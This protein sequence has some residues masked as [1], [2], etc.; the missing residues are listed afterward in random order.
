MNIRKVH[1]KSDLKTFID[2]PHKLYK[3]D[4]NYVPQLFVAMKELM[5]PD[6]NPWF[7]HSK[8]DLFL[9]EKQ[10]EIVGRIAAIRNNQYID[11]SG[12]PKGFFGFF[13][14]I[15]DY[16]VARRLLDHVSNWLQ[17]ENLNVM[18]GPTN[19]STND[20][21]G[22][23]IEGFDRPPVVEMTYNYPYYQD[24]LERWGLLKEMDLLAYYVPQ[25]T[26][27]QK[28]VRLGKLLE[29]RLKRKGITI[30]YLRMKDFKKELQLVKDIYL[31]AWE[32]NWGFVPPTEAEFDF[33]AKN[34][35]SIIKTEYCPIAEVNGKGI[36]FALAI[37]D[38][39]QILIK[40]KRGRLLPTGIF[41]LLLGQKN[42][43]MLRIITLG[44]IPEYRKLG[45]EALFYA[46]IIENSRKNGIKAGEGSWV[47]ENNEMMNQGMLNMNAYPYKR[48]R[49]YQ[50]K[51]S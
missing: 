15:E 12:E 46:R 26:V 43:D 11:F 13:D 48:Y 50:R 9:A 35:K 41:K 8:A 28:S 42:I 36:G 17:T 1:T 49:I 7:Q 45:I 51:I 44:V 20:T 2:F 10:G 47:L 21:A 18:S 40:I 32:N 6:K 3:N 4:P 34:L 19:F 37:P 16:E 22:L 23:L 25:D 24:F 31:Q 27:S 39:N 30:R 33:L 5:S 29:E 38:I 14:V